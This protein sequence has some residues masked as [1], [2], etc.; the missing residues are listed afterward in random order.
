MSRVVLAAA[1]SA[2][3]APAY[4][5]VA[6]FRD[7]P[8]LPVPPGFAETQADAPF[9]GAG[10]IVFAEALGRYDEAIAARDFFYAAL[11]ALG[12]A[13]SVEEGAAVFQRG[14]ER[15][16]LFMI[17]E[18]ESVRLKVQLVVQPEAMDAR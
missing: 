7:I 3:A 18:G 2:L 8:D 4:A 1:M 11:P 6:Y 15:L 9:E 10:R 17:R 14:R 13:E 12:W 16:H 5:D